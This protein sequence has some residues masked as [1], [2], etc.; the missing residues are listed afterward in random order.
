MAAVVTVSGNPIANNHL[1]S[2]V[3]QMVTKFAFM[4]QVEM[5]QQLAIKYI[6]MHGFKRSTNEKTVR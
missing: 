5:L 6:E 1:Q 3:N 4:K 2:F